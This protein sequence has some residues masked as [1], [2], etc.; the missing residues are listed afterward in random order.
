MQDSREPFEL[1][2]DLQSIDRLLRADGPVKAPAGLTERIFAAS[3]GELPHPAVVGRIGDDRADVSMTLRI[4]R[5]MLVAA[6]VAIVAAAALWS[7][8]ATDPIM[9]PAD[10]SV[11]AID[12]A[13]VHYDEALAATVQSIDSRIL[14]LSDQLDQLAD[15]ADGYR[16]PMAEAFEQLSEE[17]SSLDLT[18]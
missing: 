9:P 3:V 8:M 16:D 17:L 1:D 5:V 18:P 12:P 11:A 6:G 13:I 7:R 10:T 4:R 15:G 14:A 2:R